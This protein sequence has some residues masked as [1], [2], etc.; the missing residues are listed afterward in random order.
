MS[1]LENILRE[2]AGDEDANER[3]QKILLG[4]EKARCSQFAILLAAKIQHEEEFWGEYISKGGG[5]EKAT[6]LESQLRFLPGMT[7]S[8]GLPADVWGGQYYI[9]FDEVGGH[10]ELVSQ[11]SD[12]VEILGDIRSRIVNLKDPFLSCQQIQKDLILERDTLAQ[13]RDSLS[14]NLKSVRGQLKH[15][16]AM[17]F[18]QLIWAAFS[19]LF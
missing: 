11:G 5:N 10:L 4:Y 18:W 1:D 2:V 14:N 12:S 7:I 15:Y 9:E 6:F 17:G 19:R 8:R 3:V 16:E 13:E